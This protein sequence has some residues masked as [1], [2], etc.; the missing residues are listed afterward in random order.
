MAEA[1]ESTV[2]AELESSIPNMKKFKVD[3]MR[4]I[5]YAL[6]PQFLFSAELGRIGLLYRPCL[7]IERCAHHT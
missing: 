4:S 6:Y 7:C 5:A 2:F 3:C 1:E